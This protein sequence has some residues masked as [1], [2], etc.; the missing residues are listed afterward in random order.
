M[1]VEASKCIS[2]NINKI[3]ILVD[4]LWDEIFSDNSQLKIFELNKI[5]ALV[6]ESLDCIWNM[7]YGKD[8]EK[9]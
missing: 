5:N 6:E 3:R 1:I 8:R 7:I 9:N 2:N 4:Y